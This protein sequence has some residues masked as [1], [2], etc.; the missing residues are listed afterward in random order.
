MKICPAQIKPVKGNV[1]A[2]M[3]AHK[4]FIELALARNAEAIFLVAVRDFHF[5]NFKAAIS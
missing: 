1:S 4:R 2:N 5:Q 3:E